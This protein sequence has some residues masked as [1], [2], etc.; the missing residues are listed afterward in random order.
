[1]GVPQNGWLNM[2]PNGKSHYKMDDLGVP[3]F[4]ETHIY[5]YIYGGSTSGLWMIINSYYIMI[6]DGYNDGS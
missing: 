5:I 1:M 4:Q 3:L 6:N 2:V